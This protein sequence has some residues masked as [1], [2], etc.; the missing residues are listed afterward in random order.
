MLVGSLSNPTVK[1]HKKLQ[2]TCVAVQGI[3]G[4]VGHPGSGLSGTI[5][6]VE[7]EG[8]ELKFVSCPGMRKAEG[9]GVGCE[10]SW[11]MALNMQ[12]TAVCGCSGQQWGAPCGTQFQLPASTP[13]CG[14]GMHV[15]ADAKETFYFLFRSSALQ[16][17]QSPL[18]P[19]D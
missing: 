6:C 18:D 13:L 10:T 15:R 9:L 7:Q 11:R 4:Y 5:I 3:T 1:L 2:E 14:R 12:Q 16:T 17:R 8:E 19:I